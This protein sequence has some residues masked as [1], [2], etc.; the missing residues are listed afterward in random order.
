[1]I[2][3]QKETMLLQDLK[4]QEQLCVDKY[5]K[6]ANQA[7]DGQLKQLFSSI[8]QVEQGHLN[9]IDQMIGGTVPQPKGQGG[10]QGGQQPAAPQPS[11]CSAPEKQMDAYLCQ[12]ALDTEKHVSAL[13]DTCIFEFKGEDARNMLNQIQKQEQ[14]H[15]KRIYDYM[16]ANNMYN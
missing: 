16:A 14:E 3:S 5:N 6:Y 8:A 1:M 10:Q 9:I 15:G 7:C 13:Y 2:L 12:D 4:T 11:G